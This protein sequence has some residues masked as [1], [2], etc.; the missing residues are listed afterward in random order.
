MKYFIDCGA[1]LGESIVRAKEEF[2]EDITIISFE[3]I[4]YFANEISK[5]YKNDKNILIQNSLVWIEN[6]TKKFYISPIF[7]DGSSIYSD[8][9]CGELKEDLYIEVPCFDFSEW[10]GKTFSQND[11]LIV[12]LDIEGAEYEVLHKMGIDGTLNL[13]NEFYGEFH[14]NKLGNEEAKKKAIQ[15]YEGLLYMGIHFKLWETFVPLNTHIDG[16]V[17]RPETLLI[18]VENNRWKK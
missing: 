18:V 7:T 3:P 13:V 15:V 2:G 1:H 5:I 11:Y 8:M 10:I 9:N 14:Y 16:I 6:G 17:D 12:K 4:P